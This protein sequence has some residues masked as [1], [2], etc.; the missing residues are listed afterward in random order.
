MP[1][2]PGHRRRHQ[3]VEAGLAWA[4]QKARDGGARA[5]GFPGAE[6]ILAQIGGR[7]ARRRVGLR[8]EG[9]APMRD[10]VEIFPD[11]GGGPIGTVTSGALARQSEA[12]VA[13]GMSRRRMP[14]RARVFGEVA[15]QAPAADSCKLPFVAAQFKR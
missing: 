15:R 9:R 5:G 13:M 10:G 7:A 1:L 6:P 2:R 12:P 11:A 14:K 4:I 8:P 3:P